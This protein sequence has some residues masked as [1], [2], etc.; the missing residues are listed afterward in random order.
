MTFLQTRVVGVRWEGEPFQEPVFITAQFGEPRNN[1]VGYHTG[2]DLAPLDGQPGLPISF[3][4]GAVILWCG[5]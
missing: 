1:G 2:I 5:G 4:Q 3:S